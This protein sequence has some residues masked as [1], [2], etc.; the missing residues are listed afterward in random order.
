MRF[1]E[2]SRD[3]SAAYGFDARTGGGLGRKS[4][5]HQPIVDQSDAPAIM[6]PHLTVPLLK[7]A[8]AWAAPLLVLLSLIAKR[9]L[10]GSGHPRDQ[11]P[12]QRRRR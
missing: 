1:G 10:D 6:R 9:R 7:D 5:G 8:R 3:F 12:F 4:P 2:A 11:A